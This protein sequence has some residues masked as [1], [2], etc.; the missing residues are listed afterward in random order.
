[1]AFAKGVSGNPAGRPKGLRDKR[2]RL[3]TE[4]L[5]RDE[6]AIAEKLAELAKGGNLAAIAL[7]ADYL[8]SKNKTHGEPLEL[9]D[10][11]GKTI[12]EQ[13]TQIVEA[14]AEGDITPEE[15]ATAMQVIGSQAKIIEVDELRRRLEVLEARV[16]LGAKQ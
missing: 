13:G 4:I 6:A 10:M 15:A 2:N 7:S 8:W 16:D 12:A 9:P 11:A 5:S 14:M 3:L 1:M